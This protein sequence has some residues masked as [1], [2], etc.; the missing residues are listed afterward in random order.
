MLTVI[1]GHLF[2]ALTS[3]ICYAISQVICRV[4]KDLPPICKIIGQLT[5]VHFVIQL[6]LLLWFTPQFKVISEGRQKKSS[7]PVI[8]NKHSRKVFLKSERQMLAWC[9]QREVF[10]GS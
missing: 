1:Q 4:T 3:R 7:Q 8:Q 5:R 2:A 9:G 10:R 6:H